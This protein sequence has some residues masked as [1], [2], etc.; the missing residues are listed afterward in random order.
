MGNRAWRLFLAVAW[1]ALVSRVSY[2]YYVSLGDFSGVAGPAYTAGSG[3]APGQAPAASQRADPLALRAK[4]RFIPTP[5]ELVPMAVNKLINKCH[6]FKLWDPSPTPGTAAA[7]LAAK[8]PVLPRESYELCFFTMLRQV[9]AST[10]YR[11]LMTGSFVWWA[12]HTLPDGSVRYSGH[13]HDNGDMCVGFWPRSTWI[14]FLCDPEAKEPRFV[15]FEEYD[16]CRYKLTA[17]LP[18]WCEVEQAGLAAPRNIS[19]PK[20]R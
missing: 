18:D 12:N 8:G 5:P 7:L 20:I 14:Q 17:V 2:I 15:H 10:N 4:P 13:V 9:L 16:V 19:P 6:T 11:S 1:S 3:A